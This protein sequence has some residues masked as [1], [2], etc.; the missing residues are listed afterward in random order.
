[1][2]FVAVDVETA[3]A[4]LASICQVGIAIFRDGLLPQR[5][6]SLVNPDDEFD[7]VN[8]SI[9]GIDEQAVQDAP[10]WNDLSE[11]INSF[12]EGQ[13]VVSH[14]SFDKL[15]LLKAFRKANL[16]MAECRWLDSA[17][18]VRRSWP[19]YARSGYGLS[20]VAEA[21]SISHKAHDACEDACCAGLIV[22]KAIADTGLDI[23][24]W[25]LRVQQPIDLNSGKPLLRKGNPDGAL[26]GEVLVF[27]GTLSYPR[28]EAADI[29]SCAG[30]DVTDN[31][32]KHTTLLVVGDQ[33]VRR[34]AGK[35]KSSK[36]L[37]AE[38]L[39]RKGKPLR[40]LTESDF[41]EIT[42]T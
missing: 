26:Y 2:N 24:Q 7:L 20:N 42:R 9:H 11:K 21:F 6:S 41:L 40:I 15:A 19:Q 29:A 16:P 13:I 8:I 39:I 23:E 22:L 10:T 12:I 18:I 3:N 14:T 31:V 32:T 25:L 28:R 27:T 34:L 38:E 17:R 37:K 36:Q 4:D 30:C 1:M 33:D 35:E 5:W